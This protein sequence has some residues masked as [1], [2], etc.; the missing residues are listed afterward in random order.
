M[1]FF[2]EI[3]V[4]WRKLIHVREMQRTNFIFDGKNNNFQIVVT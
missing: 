2:A 3:D 1:E 4:I